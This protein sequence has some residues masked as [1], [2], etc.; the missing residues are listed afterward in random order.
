MGTEPFGLSPAQQVGQLVIWSYPGLTPPQ[1][2]F[3]AIRAGWSRGDLL[4]REH[5]PQ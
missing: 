1:A 4:R 5:Q 3:D 2:L